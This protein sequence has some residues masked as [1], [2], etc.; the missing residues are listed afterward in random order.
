MAEFLLAAVILVAMV[1][2]SGF[3]PNDLEGV[4]FKYFSASVGL[5][6]LTIWLRALNYRLIGA[7][8]SEAR[9]Q[10]EWLDVAWRHQIAFSL[11]PSGFGDLGFP[12]IAKRHA[13]VPP[14]RALL[15]IATARVRDLLCLAALA[16]L[17]LALSS[18][19]P[20]LASAFGVALLLGTY[21]ADVLAIPINAAFTRCG[22]SWFKSIAITDNGRNHFRAPLTLCTFACWS[23]ATAGLWFGYRAA[24]VSLDA[25]EALLMLCALNAAGLV[26]ITIGGLGIAEI[27][28]AAVLAWLGFSVDDAVRLSLVAR[29]L[30]L[31]SLLLAC[32]VWWAIR[33]VDEKVRVGP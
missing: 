17:G 15:V 30:M 4:S 32:I 8:Y 3:E 10:K 9:S 5:G 31:I 28:S 14:A 7:S 12:F 24:G 18:D 16:F 11:V 22:I 19:W 25:G 33:S 2:I 6:V 26:A 29:P 13:K 21:Q 20:V 23:S 27:G 1:R